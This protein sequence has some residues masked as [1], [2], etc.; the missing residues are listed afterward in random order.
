LINQNWALN[1]PEG[2]LGAIILPAH[3]VRLIPKKESQMAVQED[4]IPNNRDNVPHGNI[5]ASTE[6]ELISMF[7]ANAGWEFAPTEL[8]Q[9]GNIW[10]NMLAYHEPSATITL[11]VRR[12]RTGGDFALGETGLDYLDATLESG[13]RKDGRPIR[14]A[15]VVYADVDSQAK[16]CL[17]LLKVI[18]FETPQDIRK[19]L[20]DPPNPGKFPGTAYWWVRPPAGKFTW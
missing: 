19:R 1:E 5:I 17:Y 14:K 3:S 6:L 4:I 8:L 18:S 10:P 2:S 12:S 16:G 15:F 20:N 7:E 9:D 11:I 13:S